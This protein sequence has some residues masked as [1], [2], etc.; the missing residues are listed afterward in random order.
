MEIQTSFWADE[1]NINDVLPSSILWNTNTRATASTKTFL[2]LCSTTCLN[3]KD[4]QRCLQKESLTAGSGQLEPHQTCAWSRGTSTLQAAMP[5]K[6]KYLELWR[7]GSSAGPTQL[8]DCGWKQKLSRYVLQSSGQRMCW[9]RSVY[10]GDR[11]N[12]GCS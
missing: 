10:A 9:W 3:S 1:T 4:P 2:V 7:G 12:E 5:G 6:L 8:Y 11:T